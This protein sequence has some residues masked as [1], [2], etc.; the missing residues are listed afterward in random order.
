MR[1]SD[2]M[3]D[4][5]KDIKPGELITTRKLGSIN[6][7]EF[8]INEVTSKHLNKPIGRYISA[9]FDR[10]DLEPG[11]L[12]KLIAC[13]AGELCA[14]SDKSSVMVIGL[15]NEGLIADS[16]GW[17]ASKSVKT[18]KTENLRITSI[19]PSVAGQ[20]GIDSDD[21]IASLIQLVGPSHIIMLDSLLSRE[22][23]RML[24]ALQ[25]SNAPL[26]F[27]SGTDPKRAIAGCIPKGVS[28]LSIGYATTSILKLT[29]SLSGSVKYQHGGSDIVITPSDCDY[30]IR[31][32]AEITANAINGFLSD[33][34]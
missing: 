34:L 8:N 17:I 14:L 11:E 16:F 13:S 15:G 31:K 18:I 26:P 20:T 30:H 22:H 7:D 12:E 32:I 29:S 5:A 24:N 1:I 3:T 2:L 4:F 21:M 19:A 10:A 33:R 28:V 27:G 6:I 9:E 23:N 25:I